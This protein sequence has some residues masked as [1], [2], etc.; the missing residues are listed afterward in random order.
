MLHKCLSEQVNAAV[1]LLTVGAE[2]TTQKEKTRAQAQQEQR[3]GEREDAKK[4]DER[5][6]GC[7]RL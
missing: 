6:K 5:D 1:L 3:R 4:H 7:A 2:H